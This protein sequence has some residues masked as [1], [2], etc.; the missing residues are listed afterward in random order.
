M[1]HKSPLAPVSLILKG[2]IDSLKTVQLEMTVT[3]DI[4]LISIV[5]N[6]FQT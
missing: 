6:V 3:E 4:M 2:V 5:K 1:H